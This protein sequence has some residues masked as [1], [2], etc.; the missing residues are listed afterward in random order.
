[1]KAT[2]QIILRRNASLLSS[3]ERERRGK[4]YFWIRTRVRCQHADVKYRFFL[5]FSF[6]P[7][8]NPHLDPPPKQSEFDAVR[9]SVHLSRIIALSSVPPHGRRRPTVVGGYLCRRTSNICCGV[10]TFLPRIQTSLRK[11]GFAKLRHHK[12]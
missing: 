6:D 4:I 1:M 3:H 11:G 2:K 12:I 7:T 10:V 8:K 5:S 9:P